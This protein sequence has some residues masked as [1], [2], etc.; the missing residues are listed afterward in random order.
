MPQTTFHLPGLQSQDDADAVMFELQD[1]P[2]VSQAEVRLAER[3]AWVMHTAMITAEDIATALLEAGY[4]A[5]P[6]Q[7]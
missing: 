5:E 3:Q 2:C 7:G 6:W 1:L 4:A